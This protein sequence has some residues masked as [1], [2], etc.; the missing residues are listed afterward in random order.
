MIRSGLQW[1]DPSQRRLPVHDLEPVAVTPPPAVGSEET[2]FTMLA[3][4][5]RGHS[6]GHLALTATIGVVDAAALGWSHPG[7]WSVA[8]V[9]LAAGAYGFWGLI[10][11]LLGVRVEAGLLEAPL[12]NA[13]RVLREVVAL[14]GFIAVLAA[15]GG[16]FGTIFDG[17]IS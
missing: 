10:D 16:M 12:T 15:A 14:V 7:A 5:A 3:A 4:R 6:V 8:A 1:D 11:R 2:I 9:F 17:W 13:I